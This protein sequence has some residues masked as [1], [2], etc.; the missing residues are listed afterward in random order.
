[1]KMTFIKNKNINYITDTLNGSNYQLTLLNC[2][3]LPD[4]PEIDLLRYHDIIIT[5]MIMLLKEH[6]SDGMEKLWN[7]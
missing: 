1:M 4:E 2:N 6:N 3:T 7:E 5:Y